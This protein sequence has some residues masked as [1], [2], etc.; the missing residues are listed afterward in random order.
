LCGESQKSIS[1]KL[2]YL[3]ATKAKIKFVRRP[4]FKIKFV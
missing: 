2:L 3:T 1:V 4:N